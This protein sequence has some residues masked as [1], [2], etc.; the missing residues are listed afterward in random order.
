M[1]EDLSAL[2]WDKLKAYVDNFMHLRTENVKEN[3]FIADISKVKKAHLTSAK[4]EWGAKNRYLIHVTDE[5]D[6]GH[7]Y[8]NLKTKRWEDRVDGTKHGD[9]YAPKG[10]AKLLWAKILETNHFKYN[11]MEI[12]ADYYQYNDYDDYNV[13][14]ASFN[15]YA[16]DGNIFILE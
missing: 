10:N 16:L 15:D 2:S 8:R 9:A 14:Y 5:A 12:D 6:N 1:S 3:M 7:Y 11:A 13:D 4:G